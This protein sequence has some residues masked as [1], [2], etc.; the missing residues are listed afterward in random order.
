MLTARMNMTIKIEALTEGKDALGTPTKT[1]AILQDNVRCEVKDSDGRKPFD[2]DI[3]GYLHSYNK[4]FTFR[5]LT[6][7]GYDCRIIYREEIY[8]ILSISEAGRSTPCRIEGYKVIAKRRE[9]N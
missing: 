6:D 8:E 2:G 4:I 1:W 3:E 5:F 7:F 9:N